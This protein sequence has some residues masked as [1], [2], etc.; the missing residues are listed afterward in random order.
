MP[1]GMHYV[2]WI[3]GRQRAIP[4]IQQNHRPRLETRGGLSYIPYAAPYGSEYTLGWYPTMNDRIPHATLCDRA[5]NALL[6]LVDDLK[7]ISPEYPAGLVC[8]LSVASELLFRVRESC[9][10]HVQIQT[11]WWDPNFMS[12]VVTVDG[13]SDPIFVVEVYV[14]T[15]G[16][17]LIR[18]PEGFVLVEGTCMHRCTSH[19]TLQFLGMADAMRKR[20]LL[21]WMPTE[22]TIH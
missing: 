19:Q 14:L 6:C 16:V 4:T 22:S 10:Y 1:L 12:H 8:H 13:A 7:R 15:G 20:A 3:L 2:P 18:W 9:P 11:H 5:D 17:E 21:A